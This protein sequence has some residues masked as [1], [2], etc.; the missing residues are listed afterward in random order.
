MK[1]EGVTKLNKNMYD[2]IFLHPRGIRIEGKDSFPTIESTYKF[3]DSL[4]GLSDEEKRSE[5]INHFLRNS[6]INILSDNYYHA[7]KRYLLIGGT[8]T[9]K[10]TVAFSKKDKSAIHLKYQM[11]RIKALSELE[12]DKYELTLSEGC[13]SYYQD[14]DGVIKIG[15][16]SNDNKPLEYEEQF[17]E[18]YLDEILGDSIVHI[19]KRYE[20]DSVHSRYKIFVGDFIEG[21][22]KE[23][24]I[25]SYRLIPL[26]GRIVINHNARVRKKLEEESKQMKLQIKMEGF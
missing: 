19:E 25:C 20:T 21:S 24:K 18:A 6:K 22:D 17:L 5:V 8:R 15:I 4:K 1:I 14:E 13:T 3:S 23:I 9:L 16:C 2:T 12:S 11:D 10:S 26:I 7:G